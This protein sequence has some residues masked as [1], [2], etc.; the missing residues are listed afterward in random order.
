MTKD[1]ESKP[2]NSEFTYTKGP[3]I[4]RLS[5]FDLQEVEA[6]DGTPIA[7]CWADSSGAHP[8]FPSREEGISN[9]KLMAAAP[10]FYVAA[11]EMV[12][13]WGDRSD[14]SVWEMHMKA[15]LEEIIKQIE[16]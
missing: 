13:A 14:L 11:K 7:R 1:Q 5:E 6:E 9:T 16:S 8:S 12:S 4:L 3:W 15:G 10:E 2:D